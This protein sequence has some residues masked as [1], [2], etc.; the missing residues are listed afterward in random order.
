MLELRQLQAFLTIAETANLTHAAARLGMQQPP[1]TRMLQALE[2]ALG[3]ALVERL[4]RGVRLTPAGLALAEE[5]RQLVA[6]AQALPQLA[7]RAAAG[8]TGRLAVGFTSSASLHPLVPEVLR[9]FREQWPGVHITLEEAGSDELGQALA[10]GRLQAAFVRSMLMPGPALQVDTVLEEPMLAAIPAGHALAARPAATL[11][12]A[13]L[14]DQPFVLYRRP[15]GPGLY[16]RILSACRA[17]GF[18]PD[19]AQEAPRLTATLS[20]VAAG[21]G[22]SLVPAS[23]QRFGAEGIVYR[24]LSGAQGLTAPLYLAAHTG[25][26]DPVLARLRAQVRQAAARGRR[27]ARTG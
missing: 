10:E 2:T 14:A 19:V 6:R 22:V 1:L 24:R 13:A 5:A 15:T 8:Q 18:S 7:Q 21:F 11:R 23:L 20:L 17:A 4:P 3:T 12:L 16:D 25:D 27:S 26:D 9:R